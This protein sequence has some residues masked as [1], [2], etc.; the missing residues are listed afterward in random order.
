MRESARTL[1]VAAGCTWLLVY[2]SNTFDVLSK[3]DILPSIPISRRILPPVAK[4]VRSSFT[5]HNVTIHDDYAWLRNIKTDTDVLEYITAENAYTDQ[6]ME[7]TTPL[8]N[9]IVT[10][11]RSLEER[12][13]KTA[14]SR[15]SNCGYLPSDVLVFWEFGSYVYWVRWDTYPIYFRQKLD[16]TYTGCE[17]IRTTGEQQV[18]L[19]LNPLIPKDALYFQLGV[20]EVNPYDEDLVAFSVDLSG[21]EDFS[22]FVMNATSQTLL[23]P[24]AGLIDTY[25]SVRWARVNDEH[26]SLQDWVLYNVIDDKWGIPTAIFKYCVT[27]CGR[28][29]EDAPPVNKWRKLGVEALSH[30]HERNAMN[31]GILVY[32]EKDPSYTVEIDSTTDHRLVMVKIAGQITSET[33]LVVWNDLYMPDAIPFLP[34]VEGIQYD[35]SHADG[36]FHVR[37]NINHVNFAIFRVPDNINIQNKTVWDW[38]HLL[39][40]EQIYAG[41]DNIFIERVE[42]FSKYLLAWIWKHGMRD[43]VI[44]DLQTLKPRLLLNG[45]TLKKVYSVFPA[46]ISDMETRLFRRANSHCFVFSN[47]SMT[48]PTTI[49]MYDFQHGS[50]VRLQSFENVI[51]PS[52]YTEE[53]LW[54]P[55]KGDRHLPI[56]LYVTY[57]NDKFKRSGDNLLVMKVYG[58]YGGFQEATFSTDIFPLLDRGIV[59]TSCHPRGDGDMGRR[60]YLDGKYEKKIHTVIDTRDCLEYVVDHGLTKKGKIALHGRSAGGL[61][62][63]NAIN[64]WSAFSLD[65]LSAYVKVVVAQVP[66]IDPVSDMI[67]PSVPWTAYEW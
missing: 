46:T 32:K 19:D 61:V 8:Q 45:N 6:E 15:T 18:V 29:V 65:Q 5:L 67:D 60:W 55:P 52:M 53:L 3:V 44:I 50:T 22:L 57:R 16:L 43:A 23:E 7:F 34:R 20:F 11:L 9:E 26:G 38:D 14:I 37:T 1:L 30:K 36:H 42:S 59:V 62:V 41:S 39:S 4:E 47:S 49:Y 27:G 33:R 40:S 51:D 63:G 25:Y 21:D 48:T 35:I 64:R 12:L 10:E 17:C 31:P 56:P 13:R 28:Q 54:V 24:A 58:S 2:I 66:F